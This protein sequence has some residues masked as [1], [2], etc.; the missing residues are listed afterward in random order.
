ML[1][2]PSF[3]GEKDPLV[4]LTLVPGEE[5]PLVEL[6]LVLGEEDSLVDHAVPGEDELGDEVPLLLLLLRPAHAREIKVRSRH[7][8][9]GT[10]ILPQKYF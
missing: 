7:D 8:Q 5:N 3:F 4:E 1:S 2:L 9:L 10:K 6:T